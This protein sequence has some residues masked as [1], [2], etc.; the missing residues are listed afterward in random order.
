MFTLNGKT[1]TQ[2][3]FAKYIETHQTKRQ[4]PADKKTTDAVN[5]LFTAMY[6]QWVDD[7][8]IAYEESRLEEKYP[9]FKAL[10]QEYRDG[11]LLFELTDKKV[12][13]KAVKDTVGLKEFYE[14]NKGNYMW[15]E[16]AD[17][18][19]YTAANDKI[20]KE[21][22]K[23]LAKNKSEKQI[24]EAINKSSQ[25]NLQVESR[26]FQKGENSTVDANWNPG[27]SQDIKQ[28]NGKVAIV[29]VHKLLKPE[30]KSFNEAKGLVT[31]DYQAYLEKEWLETLR[32]KY[33][34]TVDR[35]VL[36]TI[37]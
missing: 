2:A 25:L 11:I 26:V 29:V 32:K 21:V 20:A 13:S 22:R 35:N 10:M 28:D 3:D 5:E 9:D 17:V 12:W 6:K 30:P 4:K 16:R 18:S 37:K 7:S 1:Y 34:V 33:P 19:I 36:G 15:E 31:A 24:L 14:K 23:M 8:V 27:I